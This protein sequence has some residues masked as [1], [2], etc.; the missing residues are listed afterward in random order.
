MKVDR[1]RFVW[2]GAGSTS[3]KGNVDF[4]VDE[5]R[6]ASVVP[7]PPSIWSARR[8]WTKYFVTGATGFIGGRVVRQLIEAGHKVIAVVRNPSRAQDLRA[9]GVDVRPGD[10][11]VAESLW[12]P[13]TGVDGVFH[14]AG[15]YKIGT[16]DRQEGERVNVVG[17]RNVLT[18]MEELRIPKGVY[19][20]TLAVF[21]DTH[22]QL[23]DET[24]RQDGKGPWLT[25][26]DR[27]KWVAHYEVAEPMIREGLPLVIVQ[28][29]LNYG[30]GT[31]ARSGRP[32][33][34]IFGAACSRYQKKR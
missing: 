7:Y 28:P 12:A 25:E 31:R 13:M 5:P 22:G 16:K 26:Y 21:S 14:I 32:W 29:G 3:N 19:T 15:W 23:V 17:T 18:T 8:A 6:S 30:L 1:R 4:A 9:L 10:V 2:L 34:D 33:C 11:A 24:Y 20:S 27:T